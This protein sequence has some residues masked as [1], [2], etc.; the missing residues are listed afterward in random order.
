[1]A[2]ALCQFGHSPPPFLRPTPWMKGLSYVPTALGVWWGSDVQQPPETIGASHHT[3]GIAEVEDGMMA[4]RWIPHRSCASH[5][6]WP[7]QLFHILLAAFGM[8]ESPCRA[9]FRG[10]W[11]WWWWVGG[12]RGEGWVGPPPTPPPVVLSF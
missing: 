4:R 10:V 8:S 12:S 7:T 9:P 2:S 5:K 6:P 1:M 11:W 3:K